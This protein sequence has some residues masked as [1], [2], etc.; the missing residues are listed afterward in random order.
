MSAAALMWPHTQNV[1]A[2]THA[3]RDPRHRAAAQPGGAALTLGRAATCRPGRRCLSGALD[4]LGGRFVCGLERRVDDVLLERPEVGEGLVHL[5]HG[6]KVAE[7]IGRPRDSPRHCNLG[8]GSENDV[9]DRDA[10]CRGNCDGAAEQPWPDD[11][12][13]D[14]QI[15]AGC[16]LG[17]RGTERGD[18]NLVL[19]LRTLEV[20]RDKPPFDVAPEVITVEMDGQ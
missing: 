16:I 3:G 12:V 15:A 2:T 20:R 19:V 9:G 8:R 18:D 14:G 6:F 17:R 1:P 4:D 10:S 5:A 7:V 11:C 13:E